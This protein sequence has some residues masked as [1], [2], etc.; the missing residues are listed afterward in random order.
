M[1]TL[2]KL[3]ITLHRLADATNI[4]SSCW[5]KSSATPPVIHIDDHGHQE[6]DHRR[7][8]K[9]EHGARTEYQRYAPGPHTAK[10]Q[11]K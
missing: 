6:P 11:E 7:W 1:A 4:A 9:Q 10:V 2:R 3:A 8:K 5:V